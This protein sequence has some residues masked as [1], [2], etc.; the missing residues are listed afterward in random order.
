MLPGIP[1]E[2]YATEEEM[3]GQ[4]VATSLIALEFERWFSST[5][6]HQFPLF[7]FYKSS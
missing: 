2:E 5:M 4:F 1:V 6:T 3:K 7:F